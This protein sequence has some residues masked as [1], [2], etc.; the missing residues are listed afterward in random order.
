MIWELGIGIVVIYINLV[1]VFRFFR[2]FSESIFFFGVDV[3][4][5]LLFVFLG[6]EYEVSGLSLCY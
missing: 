3:F 4:W 2:S 6:C 1:I 5:F